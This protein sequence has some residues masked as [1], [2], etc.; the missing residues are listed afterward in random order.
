MAT[1]EAV[2]R[3]FLWL[4]AQEPEEEL[5]T[6]MRL[7]KLL[8]YAQGWSLASRGRA[9]F[10]GE[11]QAWQHGPVVHE[12]YSRFA[13]F[14]AA[15]I[16]STLAADSPELDDGEKALIAWVWGKEG[17]Y[18]ASELRRRTHQERPWRESRQGVREDEASRSPISLEI[19]RTYFKEE[20]RKHLLSLGFDPDHWEAAIE[21]SRAGRSIPLEQF[22]KEV[23]AGLAH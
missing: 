13:A 3:Y 7:Q 10:E 20:Y 18:S 6:H 23:Q 22:I 9:L 14:K 1:A 16:P 11:I 19:M 15:P 5:V 17:R 12:V 4:A 8:Y 21:D 2:A